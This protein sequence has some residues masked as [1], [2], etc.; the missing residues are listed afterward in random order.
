MTDAQ[1][2]MLID[3][4]RKVDSIIETLAG[5][6]LGAKGLSHNVHDLNNRFIIHAEDNV[7]N[8]NNLYKFKN[9]AIGALT[10]IGA[11]WTVAAAYIIKN[12]L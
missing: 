2:K 8:F 6:N 4:D 12:L 11:V 10:I 1:E 3:L 7:R 9:I 5:N